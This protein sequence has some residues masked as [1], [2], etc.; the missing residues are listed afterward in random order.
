L[1]GRASPGIFFWIFSGFFSFQTLSS[2][3]KKH[4]A[5]MALP[6]LFLPSGICRVLHSAK[7]VN[8]V[9]RYMYQQN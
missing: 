8:P 5:K 1:T 3:D 7:H 4:S 2:D 9:V 6:T